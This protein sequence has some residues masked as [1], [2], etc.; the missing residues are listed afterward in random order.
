MI[1]NKTRYNRIYDVGKSKIA[2]N[3]PQDMYLAIKI[4]I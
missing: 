4:I 2:V 1:T 3:E